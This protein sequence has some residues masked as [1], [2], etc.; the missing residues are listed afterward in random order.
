MQDDGNLCVYQNN[1]DGTVVGL[2]CSMAWQTESWSSNSGVIQAFQ[3]NIHSA[4]LV[5]PNGNY[6]LAMD[7]GYLGVLS[8]NNGSYTWLDSCFKYIG[9]PFF[10]SGQSGVTAYES[11]SSNNNGA[12]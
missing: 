7:Q 5:S 9:K 12:Q 10:Y 1:N 6:F 8:Y 3:Y 4:N 11:E 2:W